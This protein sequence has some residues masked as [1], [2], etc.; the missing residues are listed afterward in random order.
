M[1]VPRQQATWCLSLSLAEDC[2]EAAWADIKHEYAPYLQSDSIELRGGSWLRHCGH[3]VQIGEK[4][5]FINSGY[6]L[7]H[8]NVA[9]GENCYIEAGKNIFIGH[10]TIIEAEAYISGSFLYVVALK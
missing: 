4:C 7:L 2:G 3:N 1:V 8:D 6:I 9:I 10:D 5:Q